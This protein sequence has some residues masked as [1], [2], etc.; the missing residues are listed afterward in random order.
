MKLHGWHRKD[1]ETMKW[2]MIQQVGCANGRVAEAA[3]ATE[4]G[5]EDNLEH[6]QGRQ[7]PATTTAGVR[8]HSHY[9][10]V[11]RVR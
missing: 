9:S 7:L 6:I 11:I 8:G 3:R 4:G 5:L 2:M 10:I 1:G